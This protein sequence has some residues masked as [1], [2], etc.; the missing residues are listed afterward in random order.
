VSDH[1]SGT[2]ITARLKRPTRCVFCPAGRE[3]SQ[4]TWPCSGR[5]LPCHVCYQTRG[6]LLPHLFNLTLAGGVFSVALSVA[7]RHPAVSRRPALWSSD[8]PQSRLLVTAIAWRTRKYFCP[9]FLINVYLL[10]CIP[11]YKF[12]WQHLLNLSPKNL[13]NFKIR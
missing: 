6:A 1:L 11:S 4:L 7:S 8:F 9:D 10:S 12:D 2:R 13:K 3:D 5:G